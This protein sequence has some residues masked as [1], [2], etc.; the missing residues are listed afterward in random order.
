MASS[1]VP[2][3]MASSMWAG[4]GVFQM[5]VFISVFLPVSSLC[6]GYIRGRLL[7]I[8]VYRSLGQ[9]KVPAD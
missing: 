6:V 5:E 1:W 9:E 7:V 8:L 4:I 2:S 3:A